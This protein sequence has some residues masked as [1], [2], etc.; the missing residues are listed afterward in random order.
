MILDRAAPSCS[1]VINGDNETTTLETTL[2]LLSTDALS[3]T[4]Q[5]RFRNES[6]ATWSNWQTYA[7]NA[8]WTLSNENAS[9][10]GAYPR[11]VY[12]QFRDQA[13]NISECYDD[14]VLLVDSTL[15]E[16]WVMV[17]SDKVYVT[18]PDLTLIVAAWDVGGV[19]SMRF[20]N[21]DGEW[22]D[23]WQPYATRANWTLRNQDGIRYIWYQF[24]DFAGHVSPR[25][26]RQSCWTPRPRRAR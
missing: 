2:T 23:N 12:A 9:A 25:P 14:I 4:K 22:L 18:T 17:D 20:K 15:P 6:Q 8:D 21:D 16:G 5:M 3:G 19:K 24:A 11:R 10:Q 26:A 13:G 1:I 7:T